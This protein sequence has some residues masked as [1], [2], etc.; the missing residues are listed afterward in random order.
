MHNELHADHM[1]GEVVQARDIHGDVHFHARSATP[2]DLAA[3]ELATAVRRQWTAEAENRAL[4][5]PEPLRVR[6]RSAETSRQE[7]GDGDVRELASTF[8]GLARRQL[9]VLGEPGAGKTVAALL[10]TLELLEKRGPVPIL[11]TASLWDPAAEHFDAWVVRRLN[12]DYPALCDVHAYGRDAAARLVAENQVMVVLDGVDELPA[13]LH[14]PALDGVNRASGVRPVVVTCRSQEYRAAVAESGAF[15]SGAAVVELAPVLPEAVAEHIAETQLD[16][17]TRWRP[18][19]AALLA[20]PGGPL[21]SALSSPLMVHLA[22]TVYASPGSRPEELQLFSTHEAIES[23]LLGGYVPTVYGPRVDVVDTYRVRRRTSVWPVG[24]V[25]RW[26]KVLA[27]WPGQE[28]LWWHLVL[29]FP[30]WVPAAG[31]SL[32]VFVAYSV[33]LWLE[34]GSYGFQV[35]SFPV[36]CFVATAVRSR[37]VTPTR[38][39]MTR[40]SP[41]HLIRT[42][43]TVVAGFI[44]YGMAIVAEDVGIWL[45]VAAASLLVGWRASKT[46]RRGGI[47]HFDSRVL[48]REDRRLCVL[49]LVL[50]AAGHAVMLFGY[51][52]SYWH[53]TSWLFPFVAGCVAAAGRT[54][55]ASYQVAKTWLAL[56]GDVPWRLMRFLDDARE[57]GVLRANGPAYQF[58]H[59]RLRD[60]LAAS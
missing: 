34:P 36:I 40:F 18:V 21:A 25:A 9:V 52:Y 10:L 27:R 3:H 15:L 49:W 7:A 28:F 32:V 45:A 50:A 41:F 42:A 17:D 20:Q 24:D 57:R 23:V 13:H 8:R 14:A 12:E 43:A 51:F 1:H 39:T 22:R 29:A 59:V 30:R 53:I 35:V 60:H 6:F 46:F 37:P 56:R 4:Y 44:C 48:L 16:A 38:P 47:T 55:W 54:A 11:L 2:L 31:V 26:L 19:T 58:R 5:Q 33:V